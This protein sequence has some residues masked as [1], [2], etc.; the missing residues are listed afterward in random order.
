[1]VGV[2]HASTG[3][4]VNTMVLVFPTVRVEQS[5]FELARE[6]GTR[7]VIY[8]WFE[9]VEVWAYKTRVF[10][11]QA[12]VHSVASFHWPLIPLGR[13]DVSLGQELLP[14]DLV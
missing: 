6:K 11:G 5:F 9:E 10:V 14:I 4:R 2:V 3:Q 8:R 1:M 12:L 13:G 7:A